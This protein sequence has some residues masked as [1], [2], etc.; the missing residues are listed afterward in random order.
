MRVFMRLFNRKLMSGKWY[1]DCAS[2]N[3]KKVKAVETQNAAGEW[4]S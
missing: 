2:V 1:S 4:N 3:V